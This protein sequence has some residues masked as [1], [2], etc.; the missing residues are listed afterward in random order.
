[1]A[2][3]AGDKALYSDL[4][5]WYNV[6]NTFISSYGGGAIATLATPAAG[7]TIQA[8]HINALYSKINE[9]K[10]DTYLSTKPSFWISGTAVSAGQLIQAAQITPITQTIT[11]MGQVKCRNITSYN[12]GTCSS[13]YYSNTSCTSGSH[14]S[15][16]KSCGKRTYSSKSCGFYGSGTCANGTC[17][18]G[19]KVYSAK[20]CGA[21]GNGSGI[22][23]LCANSSITN[24]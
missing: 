1:M 24:V 12:Y 22:N 10:T 9:F 5:N 17:T 8:A 16:S 14:S 20:S 2:T 3:N 23:I 11:N 21:Y 13:G 7:S 18:N 4:V 15:G 19:T 6:F